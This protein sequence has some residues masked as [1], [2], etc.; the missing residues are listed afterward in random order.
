M[1]ICIYVYLYPASILQVQMLHYFL[2]NYKI[3]IF[4]S[5]IFKSLNMQDFTLQYCQINT[6]YV[7]LIL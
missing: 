4:Y 3:F 5:F 1:Y 2:I 7:H 6:F